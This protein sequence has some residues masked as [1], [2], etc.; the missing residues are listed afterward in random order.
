MGLLPRGLV[1]H[2]EDKAEKKYDR[3]MDKANAVSSNALKQE[4]AIT[5]QRMKFGKTSTRTN[6]LDIQDPKQ[7]GL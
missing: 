5:R 4:Q 3:R 7:Y 2:G 6:G 1:K